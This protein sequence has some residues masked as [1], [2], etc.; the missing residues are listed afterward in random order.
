[1]CNNCL[2]GYEYVIFISEITDQLPDLESNDA[3]ENDGEEF[4][5]DQNGCVRSLSFM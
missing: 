4:E 5:T 3:N 2:I 1:M